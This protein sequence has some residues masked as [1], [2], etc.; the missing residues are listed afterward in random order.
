MFK[1][2]HLSEHLPSSAPQSH[3]LLVS[4]SLNDEAFR[5]ELTTHLFNPLCGQILAFGAPIKTVN[6]RGRSR[7]HANLSS[8][9]LNT[10]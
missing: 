6:R 8:M 5:S 1:L 10:D 7:L 4:D 3:L 9:R 2:Q